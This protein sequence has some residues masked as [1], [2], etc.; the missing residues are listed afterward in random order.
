[1]DNS[2]SIMVG[3]VV[4]GLKLTVAPTLLRE[5]LGEEAAQ[6]GSQIAAA[7]HETVCSEKLG[8][9][10]ALDY[11]YQRPGVDPALLLLADQTAAFVRDYVTEKVREYL[12]PVFSTVQIRRMQVASAALPGIR[13]SQP[14]ALEALALH[15]LPNT[16]QLEL[17]VTQ[18]HKGEPPA[19]SEKI[20]AQK[21][22]WWLRSP[23][24]TVEV[25]AARAMT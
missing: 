6:L 23:F 18:L 15:Y 11:F 13:P 1:M 21:L 4:V 14:G 9:Y 17:L 25:T 2:R 10:P 12:Q 8:Y 7:V 19:G 24:G 16:V 20:A 5:R 3:R 22:K